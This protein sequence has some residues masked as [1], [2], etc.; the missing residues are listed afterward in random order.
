MD[1]RFVRRFFPE[2]H[3]S[4]K[5]LRLP[6]PDGRLKEP[7]RAPERVALVNSAVKARKRREAPSRRMNAER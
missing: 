7:S 3:E 1:G 2:N 5:S 4:A 6:G